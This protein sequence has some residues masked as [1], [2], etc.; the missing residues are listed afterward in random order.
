MR[1]PPPV[2]AFR[3]RLW[4]VFLVLAAWGPWAGRALA[5]PPARAAAPADRPE[6][7]VY[8]LR[9][10]RAADA[11]RVLRDLFRSP[12]ERAPRLV[13]TSDERTNS[14]IV[15]ALPADQAQVEALLNRI[16]AEAPPAANMP[17][18]K[19]FQLKHRDTDAGLQAALGLLF[20]GRRPGRFTVIGRR[21]VLV[22]ADRE[23]LAAVDTLLRDLDAAPE[24]KAE[25]AET[26]LEVRVF[27][28]VGG[29]QREAGKALDDFKEA[30]AELA[31]LGIDR[32]R[33]AAQVAVSTAPQARFEMTGLASLDTPCRV[34]VTGTMSDGKGAVRLDVS[35]TVARTPAG[36][37]AGPLCHLR[38]QVTAPLDRP[39]VLGAAPAE[40]LRSAFVI[41]VQRRTP[42]SPPRKAVRFE[43]RNV[44]WGRVFEWLSDQ[45]GIP[46]IS[47]DLKPLGTF[48][49]IPP[50]EGKTYS[51]PEMIDVL[52]EALL[53]QHY[54]L[55]RRNHSFAL[56]AADALIDP[57]WLPRVRPADLEQLG[58]T[59]LVSLEVALR[60]V[61]AAN[62]AP[63]VKKLL[64][65]FGQVVV[66]KEANRLVLQD[67]AG[68]LRRV[69][70]LLED[71]E[72]KR[73]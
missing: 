29:P 8:A 56:L 21:Q 33:L 72:G 24:G 27:W 58:R 16:D 73:K 20:D 38:T 25:P 62:V 68:N 1:T 41:Q 40:T 17:A 60:S 52:N 37:E 48:T 63:D 66:L 65:P 53:G 5:E 22:Y 44:P 46:F 64:G 71:I 7:C 70:N 6:E 67:T 31:R 15:S 57:G 39:L 45:T 30:T 34:A 19:V 59:E 14:V 36:R 28:V 32:P 26:D 54:L 55:V 10:A 50:V 43:F 47:S 12:A 69:C 4:P 61:E 11:V 2:P 13:I 42:P 9:Y 18:L 49:F 51:I 3:V 23:T 35:I